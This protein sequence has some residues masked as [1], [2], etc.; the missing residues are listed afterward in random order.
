MMRVSFRAADLPQACRNRFKH[1][2]QICMYVN[3]LIIMLLLLDA[4]HTKV[5]GKQ[6][7]YRKINALRRVCAPFKKITYRKAREGERKGRK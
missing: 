6:A 4:V 7:N 5:S 1:K 2:V 3:V